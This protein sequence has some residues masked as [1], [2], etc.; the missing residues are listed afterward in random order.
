MV[1]V[2][3]SNGLATRMQ[4]F[5]SEFG[6]FSWQRAAMRHRLRQLCVTAL[7]VSSALG[8]T[9]LASGPV[10]DWAADAVWYQ[11]F[12][13]RFAN[14]DAS[15]DPTRESLEFPERVDA[16][17]APSSWTSDWYARSDWERA[18]GD[19]FYRDGVYDRRYGGDL[20]G[21]LDR[22]D[23]LADLGVNALYFNPLFAA[24]S[25]HKYDGDVFHHIDPHFGP[26]PAGDRALIAEEKEDPDTWQWTAADRLFLKLV[27]ECHKRKI[28]LIIDGVFNH[29]G[30]GCFAF[31]DLRERQAASPYRDWY[32]VRSFDDPT[33]P[34]DEFRYEGWWGA[35]TL[36]IFAD[37]AAGDDLAAGPKAYVLAATRRWLD[38]DG[39]GDPADG[40]DGWR[41]DVASEVPVGFWREWNAEVRRVNP[42]AY[43]VAEHWEDAAPFVVAGGFSAAM[44][45]HG[46]ALPVK[47]YVIDGD[48][49]PTAFARLMADRANAY[50]EPQ[51]HAVQNLIDSHDTERVASMIVN[52]AARLP[53]E[54]AERFDYDFGQRL[55]PRTSRAYKVRKPTPDERRIQRIVALLQATCVGAPM[56]YH[57]TEAGMWGADDPDDRKPM[58]WP[59][60]DYDAESHNPRGSDRQ[61]DQVVFDHDLHVFYRGTIRLRKHFPALRRGSFH[62]VLAH[63]AAKALVFR[64]TL[65]DQ[66]LY[67]A[68][69]RG[70]GPW[71]A[72]VPV[73]R[74]T[75]LQEV[76]TASGQ[77]HRVRV[78]TTDEGVRITLPERD[79]AVFLAV[80]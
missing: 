77:P 34:A 37:N 72:D 35:A 62:P 65:D 28:R 67:V 9:V 75:T 44:N 6:D 63:D 17:W 49:S 23:Y 78:D 30:R 71:S 2:G 68:V 10:P 32:V 5:P 70:E 51:R 79:G 69:N 31:R 14:G 3:I 25:L 41:L 7:A 56:L 48:L 60:L 16:S 38:P 24:A 40:V 22:L 33:T 42:E 59:D 18:R 54:N 36:P 12:P 11:I 1:Y 46:F 4:R 73:P 21:V 64:R 47:G 53:Y 43:T 8:T 57:G 39:D 20:Q 27:R 58:I 74:G 76:F 52:A 61:P 45:Y 13:E 50:A 15:N 19:D 66:T 80:P 55:S 29:T 26:D